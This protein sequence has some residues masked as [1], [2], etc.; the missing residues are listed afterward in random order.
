MLVV[1][2]RLKPVAPVARPCCAYLRVVAPEAPRGAPI[3]ADPHILGM[4][5]MGRVGNRER[6]GVWMDLTWVNYRMYGWIYDD[7]W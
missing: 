4:G 7:L 6:F 2:G 5:R 1:Y 3:I